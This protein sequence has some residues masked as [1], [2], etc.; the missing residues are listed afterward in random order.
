MAGAWRTI[1]KVEL[2]GH[3][4]EPDDGGAEHGVLEGPAGD[5]PR[6]HHEHDEHDEDQDPENETPA[7]DRH[8]GTVGDVVDR[9]AQ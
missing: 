7:V 6:S 9:S 3:E 8:Q 5:D 1:G 2:Q 4:H